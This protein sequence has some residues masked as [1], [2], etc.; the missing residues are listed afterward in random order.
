M[1]FEF[2][3]IGVFIA[4][5]LL[6]PAAVVAVVFLTLWLLYRGKPL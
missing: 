5:A 4:N 2:L 3:M 1:P 6:W